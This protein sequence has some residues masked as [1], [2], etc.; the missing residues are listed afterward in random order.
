VAF[1]LSAIPLLGLMGAAVDYSRA[2]SARADLQAAADAAALAGLSVSQERR[3][4]VAQQV[5]AA[6]VLKLEGMSA[7][8]NVSLPDSQRVRVEARASVPLKLFSG[9]N[10]TGI[11]V[12]AQAT[13]FRP[14]S[15]AG[16]GCFFLL[17][18]AANG[19]LRINGGSRIDAPRCEAHVRSG[20]VDSFIF[21]AGSTFNQARV[22]V[23]GSALLNGTI[24]NVQQGCAA[25]DDPYRSTIPSVTAGACDYTN[26]VFNAG[27]PTINLTPGVYC[28]TTIFNGSP[29]INFAPGLY[30]IRDGT[31]IFNSGSIV[32]GTGVTFHFTGNACCGAGLTMNG[33]MQMY[34]DA[35]TSGPYANILMFQNPSL[36]SRN[37]IFNNELG[38]KLSGLIWLPTQD[39]QFNSRSNGTDSD[40]IALVARTGI[41]NA[42]ASWRVTPRAGAPTT[43]ANGPAL[44]ER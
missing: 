7:D 12:G 29:Q 15:Q 11:N 3:I 5:F 6:N 17:D 41:F 10:T 34:L 37:F 43:V 39:V 14:S 44:L 26:Q 31:M 25:E 8:A 4:A 18:P 21:N 23:R 33:Q 20:I 9:I 30:V 32:R 40:A 35:P 1:A 22:C 13:A 36:P 28:G 24:S 38:Q 16:S 2:T 19:A 27:P 42:Q